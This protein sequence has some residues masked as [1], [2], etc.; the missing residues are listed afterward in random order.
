MNA[1]TKTTLI[2]LGS[3]ITLYMALYFFAGHTGR[4]ILYPVRI[5]VTI[6]HELGHAAGGL[7]SGA[8]VEWLEVNADGSGRTSLLGGHIPTILIG[9]YVGSAVFGNILF[10]IGVRANKLARPTMYAVGIIMILS[11]LVWYKHLFSTFALFLCGGGLI[12]LA[13]KKWLMPETLMFLGLASLI[14]IIQDFNGGPSSDLAHYAQIYKI[15]PAKVWAYIWLII[16][17]ILTAFNIRMILRQNKRKT[18]PK[19]R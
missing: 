7:I 9:G 16:V 5:F 3:V 15:I 19:A 2:R 13:Y 17:L 18:L 10:Y 11:G 8:K 6:L 1:T 12:G 4:G 14:Y